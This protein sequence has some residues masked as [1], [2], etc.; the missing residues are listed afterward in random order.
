MKR[1]LACL[2]AGA[3][4][5]G[6]LPSLASADNA[7]TRIKDI[8]KVQGVR[9]NQLVGY[10]LVVGLNGTGD[11]NKMTPT[12]QSIGNRQCAQLLGLGL[13]QLNADYLP[14]LV[15]GWLAVD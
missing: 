5:L 10:G 15:L 8:A 3:L 2:L 4:V 9:S 12:I 13:V 7:V 11:S 6:G 14:R 1:V